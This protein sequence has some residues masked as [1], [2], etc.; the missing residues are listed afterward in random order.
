VTPPP[1]PAAVVALLVGEVARQDARYGPF[2]PTVAGLRLAVAC[3]QDETGE[4][5]QARWAGR[6]AGWE[7]LRSE[8]LQAAAVAIRLVRSLDQEPTRP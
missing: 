6:Q 4:T 5:L 8:A 7:A 1:L 2:P 3:R